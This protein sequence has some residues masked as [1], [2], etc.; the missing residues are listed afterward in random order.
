MHIDLN[1]PVYISQGDDARIAIEGPAGKVED[2]LL[3]WRDGELTLG[4]KSEGFF[5]RFLAFRTVVEDNISIYIRLPKPS[6]IDAPC[7]ANIITAE[8]IPG[9]DSCQHTA[10]ELKA[11]EFLMNQDDHSLSWMIRATQEFNWERVFRMS[12]NMN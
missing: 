6:I 11:S 10:S 2:V 5:A 1:Y 8:D 12:F 3:E 4:M 9:L 7:T